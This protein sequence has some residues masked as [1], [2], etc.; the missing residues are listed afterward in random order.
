MVRREGK[1]G[2]RGRLSKVVEVG[3]WPRGG[4]EGV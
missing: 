2:G 3:R 4:G 1:E